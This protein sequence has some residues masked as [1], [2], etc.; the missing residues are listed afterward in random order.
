[1]LFMRFTVPNGPMLPAIALRSSVILR[2]SSVAR[3]LGLIGLLLRRRKIAERPLGIA[4]DPA[5]A[6]RSRPTLTRYEFDAVERRHRPGL[7]ISGQ[8]LVRPPPDR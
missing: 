1:M 8:C 6:K 7:V 3:A 5:G 2:S 4:D